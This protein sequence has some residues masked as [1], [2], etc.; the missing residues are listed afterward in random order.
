MIEWMES[1]TLVEYLKFV[2]L[3]V[4]GYLLYAKTHMWVTSAQPSLLDCDDSY[5]IPTWDTPAV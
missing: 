5:A 4:L 2:A 1:L 3:C